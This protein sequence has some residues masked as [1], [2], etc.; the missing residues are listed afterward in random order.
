MTVKNSKKILIGLVLS[1]NKSKLDDW[2]PNFE[3]FGCVTSGL[4]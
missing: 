3:S 1:E 2:K 4:F